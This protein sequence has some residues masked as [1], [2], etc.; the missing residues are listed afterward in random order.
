MIS[1]VNTVAFAIMLVAMTS[2]GVIKA[3]AQPTVIGAGAQSCGRWVDLDRSVGMADGV[4][5]SM[6]LSWVQGYISGVTSVLHRSDTPIGD[7]P[8]PAAIEGWLRNYCT[9]YP[10]ADLSTGANALVKELRR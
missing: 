2:P 3:A 8:D 4:L 5:K 1:W 7:L 10:L 9:Q 6:M